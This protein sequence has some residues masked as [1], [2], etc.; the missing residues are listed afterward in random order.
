[1]FVE[2]GKDG[3]QHAFGLATVAKNNRTF[4]FAAD[5]A[6]V[7]AEWVLMVDGVRAVCT[8]TVCESVGLTGSLDRPR[9][10]LPL[11]R[12]PPFLPT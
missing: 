9:F 12:S 3:H 2:R 5:D 6:R 4:Y 8:G 1:M 10:S 11:S 7:M